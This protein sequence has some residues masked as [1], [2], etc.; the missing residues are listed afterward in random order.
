M[1]IYDTSDSEEIVVSSF[2]SYQR[3]KCA[4]AW[5]VVEP[6]FMTTAIGGLP[7]ILTQPQSASVQMGSSLSLVVVAAGMSPITYQWRHDGVNMFGETA[8]TLALGTV[9]SADAGTYDV[10]VTNPAGAVTSDVATVTVGTAPSFSVY[11]GNAGYPQP[12]NYTAAEIKAWYNALPGS[13]PQNRSQ[14]PGGYQ[15]SSSTPPESN[16]FR[17]FAFPKEFVDH[18]LTFTSAGMNMAM[19]ILG[20]VMID[21]KLY[22][23]YRTVVRSAGDFTYD[24][25]TAITV[26]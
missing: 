1:P 9:D 23:V 7:K 19:D 18:P 20:D 6:I 10:I 12:P 17:C 3:I 15:I 8:A 21:A 24:G 16:E 25:N 13:N 11:L 4:E 22:T 2:G 26:T 14:A 5:T